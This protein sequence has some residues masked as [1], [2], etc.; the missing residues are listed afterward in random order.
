MWVAKPK[1]SS[2]LLVVLLKVFLRSF[3]LLC[4]GLGQRVWLSVIVIPYHNRL[5]LY[6]SWQINSLFS[7][8]VLFFSES[9]FPRVGLF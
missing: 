1:R 8:T 4:V 7:C 6:M 9:F 2:P 5:L 3:F